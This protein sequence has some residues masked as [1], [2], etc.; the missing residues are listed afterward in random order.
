MRLL[1]VVSLFLAVLWDAPAAAQV[2]EVGLSYK[3]STFSPRE[4]GEVGLIPQDFTIRNG[5]GVNLY[6]SMNGRSFLG[7]EL[8]YG[9]ERDELKLGQIDQGKIQVHKFHYHFV[10]HLLRRGARVRPFALAGLGFST[11]VPPDTA[12]IQAGSLTKFGASYGGGLKV[13]I[14]GPLGV[15]FD[16]RDHL[17][18][19][20]NL[21]DLAAVT[22][23]LHNVEYSG[24]FSLLF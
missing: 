20:P 14:A 18:G 17:M 8:T 15:R 23:N 22:G 11:F 3:C 16:I 2:A 1:A 13:R 7:H 9:Y 12:A 6:F 24:G 5:K 4:L 21:F 10:F 19:K